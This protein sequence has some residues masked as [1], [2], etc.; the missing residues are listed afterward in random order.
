[1]TFKKAFKKLNEELLFSKMLI[2][3]V[4]AL[5]YF[6]FILNLKIDTSKKSFEI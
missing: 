6:I 1:M 3:D 5:F 2:A 4:Y